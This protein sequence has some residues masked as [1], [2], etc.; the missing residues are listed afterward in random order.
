MEPLVYKL[1]EFWTGHILLQWDQYGMWWY[2]T[3]DVLELLVGC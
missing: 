1:F 3:D 2:Y